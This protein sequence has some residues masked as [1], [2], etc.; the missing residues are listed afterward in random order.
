MKVPLLTGEN[1]GVIYKQVLKKDIKFP[2][3]KMKSILEVLDFHIPYQYFK[4]VIFMKNYY[5]STFPAILKFLY[6]HP[7]NYGQISKVYKQKNI[8]LSKNQEDIFY[9]IKENKTSL[10]FGDTGSGKTFIYKKY[11]DEVLQ[12]DGDILFLIPEIN[13]IPQIFERVSNVFGNCVESWHS[14]RVKNDKNIIIQKIYNRDIRIIIGTLSS[15]FMPF[16]KLSLIIVD[17]EHSESYSL[18]EDRIFR[19]NAKDMA[20]YLGNQLNIPVLLGSA[21]PSLNS[22]VK[23]PSL[24]LKGQFF[25]RNKKIF[26]EKSHNYLTE[27]ILTKINERVEKKEQAIIF[28]PI[29]GNFK[30]ISCSDCGEG[31]FCKNCSIRLTLYSDNNNLRCNR[32]GYQEPIPENC[33]S[34]NSDILRVSKAGTIEVVKILKLHFPNANII[35]FDSDKIKKLNDVENILQDFKEQKID[36]L[37]GTQMIAKGHD[38]P[39]VTLSVILGLDFSINM[40]DFQS[41]EKTLSLV[42]QLAGRSGRTKDSEIVIQTKYEDFYKK[43]IYD[44]EKFLKFEAENRLGLFPP[45]IN[46]IRILIEDKVEKKSRE[47]L[48]H[49]ELYI[50]IFSKIEVFLSGETPVKKISN[51]YRFHLILKTE[52]LSDAMPFVKEMLALIP[53]DFRKKMAV[54]INPSSYS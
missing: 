27:Q 54:E 18:E 32:C 25:Q 34:C 38:Y 29:R 11:I 24:R 21:T 1:K 48:E 13:L 40:T 42:V 41:Y 45:Y 16:K 49:I 26:F 46:F 53:K 36:I 33:K 7:I 22:Y 10:L 47:I 20:I 35:N 14:K 37:V 28:V 12:K 17:E 52:K 43:Y 51:K 2:I 19:F 5:F 15:L 8:E 44:Y 3:H 30:Y 6:P 9:K 31:F 50:V 39:N 4:T 23:F